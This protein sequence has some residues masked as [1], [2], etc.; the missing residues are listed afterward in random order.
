MAYDEKVKGQEPINAVNR[1]QW[2][3]NKLMRLVNNEGIEKIVDFQD[4]FIEL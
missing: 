3:D 4:D 1:I 2:I